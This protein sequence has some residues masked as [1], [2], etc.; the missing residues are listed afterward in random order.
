M[1]L[2]FSCLTFSPKHIAFLGCFSG[3]HLHPSAAWQSPV[4]CSSVP[5]TMSSLL[6][7]HLLSNLSPV[8]DGSKMAL[9]ESSGSRVRLPIGITWRKIKIIILFSVPKPYL[10]AMKPKPLWDRAG[11]S[12]LF[13]ALR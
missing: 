3:G 4:L 7:S 2:K 8:G 9:L 13:K 10:G 5:T 1:L 12:V 11:I 6:K